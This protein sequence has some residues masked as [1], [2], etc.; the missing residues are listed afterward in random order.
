MVVKFGKEP[1]F[2]NAVLFF[3]PLCISSGGLFCV[4]ILDPWSVI[5]NLFTF[6]KNDIDYVIFV[7]TLHQ[8]PNTWKIR[9]LSIHSA[10]KCSYSQTLE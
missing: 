6:L 10:L 8:F 9:V 3:F 7:Q 1:L 2:L 5:I 4:C